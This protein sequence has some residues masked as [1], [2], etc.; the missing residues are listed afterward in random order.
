MGILIHDVEIFAKYAIWQAPKTFLVLV[1]LAHS[2][3]L[4]RRNCTMFVTGEGS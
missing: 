3:G 4:K 2:D 1:K